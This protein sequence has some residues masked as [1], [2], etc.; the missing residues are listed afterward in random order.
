M[1]ETQR[2]IVKAWTDEDAESFLNLSR[3][4]GL[5]DNT[6]TLYEQKTLED[7]KDW[8]KKN[9][10]KWAVW[11]KA[12]HSIIGLGGITPIAFENE[13]LPDVTYRIRESH[14]GKGLG[15]ELARGI[16]DYAFQVQKRA[17]LTITIT[18]ENLSSAKIGL[19][20]GF[21]FEK[22]IMLYGVK[23]HLYR[24]VPE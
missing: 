9:P 19:G 14:W 5:T 1:F 22:E 15:P 17:E 10:T 6:I 24:L 2:L 13:I 8:I 7:A 11:E 3:D 12:S 20:L 18:P 23:T 21:T 16:V 4:R